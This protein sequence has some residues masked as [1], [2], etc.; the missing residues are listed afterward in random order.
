MEKIPNFLSGLPLL[1]HRLPYQPQ[2]CQTCSNCLSLNNANAW[3]SAVK[4]PLSLIFEHHATPENLKG[5]A[6]TGC[7]ICKPLLDVYNVVE[8]KLR[9]PETRGPMTTRL[10]FQPTKLYPRVECKWKFLL[11]AQVHKDA[12][13]LPGVNSPPCVLFLI[14]EPEG[15]CTSARIW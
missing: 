3:Y 2:L 7:I 4:D 1:P 6:A 10:I 8:S 9:S 11:L 5:A 13:N 12:F 14:Q 15:K